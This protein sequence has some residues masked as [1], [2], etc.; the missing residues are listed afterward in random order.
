MSND[1]HERL[2]GHQSVDC[3]DW[4]TFYVYD[5]RAEIGPRTKGIWHSLTFEQRLAIALDASDEILRQDW[6]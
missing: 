5:W 3:P 1:T 4:Q 6:S 2:A